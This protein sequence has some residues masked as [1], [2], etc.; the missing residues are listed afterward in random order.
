MDAINKHILT[1]VAALL[2]LTACGSD[3]ETGSNQLQPTQAVA[4]NNSS[5]K[6]NDVASTKNGRDLYPDI[7]FIEADSIRKDYLNYTIVD[8]RSNY[9]Y[10]ILRMADSVSIPAND[11]SFD[12]RLRNLV[13]KH[14]QTV[15]LYGNGGKDRH[16][17]D[18]ARVAKRNKID[19]ILVY[20]GDMQSWAEISPEFTELNGKAIAA[21]NELIPSSALQDKLVSDEDFTQK[22]AEG[23]SYLLDI[24]DDVQTIQY[25]LQSSSIHIPLDHQSKLLQFLNRAKL[26]DKSLL[27]Y[28]DFG[29]QS[30]WMMYQ[31]EKLDIENYCFLENGVA[32]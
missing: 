15:I 3:D 5:A 6:N 24:R 4:S 11:A 13:R 18:A 31:L 25:P 2:V 1:A 22:F 23:D 19:N 29:L 16:A 17:H 21:D 28:D 8:V 10:R 14:K 32:N 9:E 20:D 26:E 7:T 30:R 27:I 12:V